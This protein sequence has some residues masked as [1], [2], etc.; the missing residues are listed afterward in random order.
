MKYI[1]LN[2][3]SI[4]H[5]CFLLFFVITFTGWGEIIHAKE[6]YIEP[7]ISLKTEYDDNKR[8]E[9]GRF[10]GFDTSSYGVITRAIAKVG[11]RSSEYEVDV[12]N[13]VVINRY[14]SDFDLDSEDF[15]ID[16]T[17][18]YN[19]SEKSRFGLDGNFTRDTTL[20]SELQGDGTGVVEQ[21]NI[22][23]YQWSITPNW[24]YSFSNTQ[25]IQASYTHSDVEYADSRVGSFVDYS[26]DNVSVNFQQ[27]WTPQFS[28]ILSFSAMSFEIP[29]IENGFLKSSRETTEYS[30]NIG[31]EYEITPTWSTSLTVGQRFTHTE[32]TRNFNFDERIFEKVTESS[33]VQ[34]LIFSFSL[35]K[36]FEKGSA[37]ISY[38]RSTNAQGDGRL[39]VNDSY[40]ANYKHRFS[41]AFLFSL[42]GELHDRSTSGSEDDDNGR[43][44]YS[45]RPVVKWWFDSQA[46]LTASYQY[47]TQKFERENNEGVSN[48]ISLNFVYQW[49]KI[50]TQKY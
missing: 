21:D 12:N 11:V 37:D 47:R 30:I 6:I 46:S 27:Q 16:L 29:D 10:K 50:A 40:I 32:E 13:Q 19:F 44:Y 1:F 34:G 5:D 20:S 38:S 25:N 22:R 24:V 23:R 43:T 31:A 42:R 48:S 15:I 14:E 8:M 36:R 18:A 49:D 26:I 4:K 9:T 17:A 39:V 7:S 33:D 45:I 28:N 35:D 41:P 2:R 3:F